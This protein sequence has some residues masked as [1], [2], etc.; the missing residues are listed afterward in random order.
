MEKVREIENIESLK[1]AVNAEIKH[2]YTD[3]TGKK[4]KFSRYILEELYK[5]SKNFPEDPRWK[6]LYAVFEI[7]IESRRC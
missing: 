3:I 2:N 7:E 4:C 5:I 6:N 1:K